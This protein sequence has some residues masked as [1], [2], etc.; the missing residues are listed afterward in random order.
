MKFIFSLLLCLAVSAPAMASVTISSPYNGETVSSPFTLS[1]NAGWCSG[2]WISSIGYSLDSSTHT[3][4]WHNNKINTSVSASGGTH[5]IHVKSWGHAG[6]VCVADVKVTV[7]T[8]S[9]NSVSSG[10]TSSGPWKPSNAV[11]VSAIQMLSNWRAD[12]DGATGSGWAS[13]TT[14]L[15]GSPSRGGAGTRAFVTKFGNHAGERYSASFNDDAYSKNFIWDGWVYL[16]DSAKYLANLELDLNQTV[17][18]GNTVIYGFQCDGYSSTWDVSANTG[19]TTSPHG[20]WIHTGAYCNPRAWARNTWHHVQIRYSRDD[21]GNVTYYS[22][23][24]DGK[25][26][27][28]NRKVFSA[29]KLGWGK[30]LLTNFQVDGLGTGGTIYAY[31]SSLTVYRW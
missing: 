22:V 25:R 15:V 5:T 9:S 17:P 24:L 29:Y 10:S 16:G 21:G 4:L 3:T 12:H 13:G 14:G 19:S 18:S 30:T 8:V 28:I 11:S 23:Y 31:L 6:S 1:A 2:Q 26:Q 27:D 20:A 7:T